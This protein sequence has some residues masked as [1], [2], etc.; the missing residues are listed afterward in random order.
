[1]PVHSGDLSR[2][3]MSAFTW[4]RENSS[5][6]G[7]ALWYYDSNSPTRELQKQIKYHAGQKLGKHLGELLAKTIK[8][9]SDARF[10]IVVPIPLHRIR[11]YQRGYNQAA[12]IARGVAREL[13][14]DYN[15]TLLQRVKYRASQVTGAR[16]D[17]LRNLEG[18]FEMI[19]D[20]LLPETHILLIDD[21]VTTGSTLYSAVGTLLQDT[22]CRVTVGTLFFVRPDGHE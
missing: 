16:S 19:P 12:D 18:A 14:V 3:L 20:N 13:G 11:F 5:P 10:D 9:E 21:V 1:L 2:F 15:E 4:P 7:H 22:L 8:R 6:G 17:R